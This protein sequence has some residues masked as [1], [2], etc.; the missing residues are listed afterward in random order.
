MKF[1]FNTMAE[2]I[3][4]YT[5]PSGTMYTIN[6]GFPFEV[7]NN[8]DIAFFKSNKRFS[9]YGL[10]QVLKEALNPEPKVSDEEILMSELNNIVG[11]SDKTKD[12][13]VEIYVT[14]KF[15]VDQIEEGYELDESIPKTHAK[16][17][18]DYFEEGDE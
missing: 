18:I 13:I 1:V 6:K 3:T 15:L 16:K 14:K 5:G 12:K 2:D 11:I 7:V 4:T 8:D 9:E 10:K 17:I